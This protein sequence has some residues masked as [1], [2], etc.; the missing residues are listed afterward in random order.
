VTQYSVVAER[1]TVSI[2][3]RS[4]V[5]PILWTAVGPTGSIDMQ[6][7]GGTVEP[8]P[9]PAARL[10]LQIENLS[11]G[12][13]LYDAELRRRID[14]R[15]YPRAI[16]ELRELAVVGDEARY[17]LQ[18][19][20]TFHGITREVRGTISARFETDGSMKVAG[21]QIFDIRDFNVPSPTILMLKIF[22]DVRVRLDLEA[23]PVAPDEGSP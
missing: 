20:L 11:S 16:V 21:E 22:P 13:A 17:Q 14:A 8:D 6:V 5:G 15:R 3:A 12:N 10:E 23:Q 19:D 9:R 2:E 1:S 18:G 4:S 7:Q